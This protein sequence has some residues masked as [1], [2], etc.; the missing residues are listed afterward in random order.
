MFSVIN[1]YQVVMFFFCL[2]LKITLINSNRLSFSF[3]KDGFSQ[4][5]LIF[6][7]H[8]LPETKLDFFPFI[9]PKLGNLD[10][11]I[12]VNSVSFALFK[13]K[14][15]RSISSIKAN[16]INNKQIIKIK[17]WNKY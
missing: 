15:T 16:H 14:K 6:Y 12:L 7:Y 13:K 8:L 2:K 11:K 5:F 4:S 3:S 17:K 10:D 9:G 1:L